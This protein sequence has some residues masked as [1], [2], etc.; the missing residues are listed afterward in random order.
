MISLS[1]LRS[2]EASRRALLG[3]AQGWVGSCQG[4][5]GILCGKR[6][7]VV[8]AGSAL[9]RG[10]GGCGVS[11]VFAGV[12]LTG[13]RLHAANGQ[14]SSVLLQAYLPVVDYQICSSSSYWGS[15]VKTT[16]VCAGG[17]GIRSGC[18][19]RPR[20]PAFPPPVIPPASRFL[21]SHPGS[22]VR[23]GDSGGPLHCEVNGRYQVHGVTSFVSSLGCNAKYKPTVFTRVSA[24]ISW[25][26][27][28]RPRR[29]SGSWG[30]E[31]WHH[32]CTDAPA[33]SL[34][35]STVAF[36]LL[37]G[38]GPELRGGR[39]RAR[40]PR[41]G[42]RGLKPVAGIN[43]ICSSL[44]RVGGCFAPQPD[45]SFSS[46]L[47]H[48][49][50]LPSSRA[51]LRPRPSS[52]SHFRKEPQGKAT[53]SVLSGQPE[54]PWDNGKGENAA[55]PL[56]GQQ[57]SSLGTQGGSRGIQSGFFSATSFISLPKPT[58]FAM[59]DV[60]FGDRYRLA[61]RLHPG[62][63]TVPQPHLAWE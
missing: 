49:F 55:N 57:C 54:S 58:S 59:R 22:S 28:V 37:P 46:N 32:H 15:T 40:S 20:H 9:A 14:L 42:Q 18:Q 8:A 35:G 52:S 39:R 27:S 34:P 29:G 56:H 36:L 45:N 13:A 26:K 24:Y 41:F 25:M 17:D 16:M 63:P 3:V 1:P 7:S 51:S 33:V 53:G 60:G 38:D 31:T 23:Q 5:G 10:R 43:K 2:Q 19:V 6:G 4:L 47:Q 61:P 44:W 62:A 50:P 11:Q 21:P 48:L 30:A 12:A